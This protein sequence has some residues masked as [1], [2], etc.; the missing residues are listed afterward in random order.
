MFHVKSEVLYGKETWDVNDNIKSL[1]CDGKENDEMDVQ[2]YNKL[3]LTENTVSH[4]L[5]I[6]YL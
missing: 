4:Y 5:F 1:E 6:I 3:G 2:C